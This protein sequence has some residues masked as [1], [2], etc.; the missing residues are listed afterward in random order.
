MKLLCGMKQYYFMDEI[1]KDTSYDGKHEE[2]TKKI[3]KNP[4]ANI[5][6][7]DGNFFVGKLLH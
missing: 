5:V 3:Y 7:F 6:Y 2:S 4:L 1:A